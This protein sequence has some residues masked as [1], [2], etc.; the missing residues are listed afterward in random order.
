MDSSSDFAPRKEC[1]PKNWPL[2]LAGSFGFCGPF[3]S[4]LEGGTRL[5][6]AAAIFAGNTIAG[7]RSDSRWMAYEFSYWG[8]E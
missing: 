1:G 4:D 7:L 5:K 8:Q 6:P 2:I 3:G